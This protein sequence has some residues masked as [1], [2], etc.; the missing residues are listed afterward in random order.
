M[1]ITQFWQQRIM[2]T[3]CVHQGEEKT[4]QATPRRKERAYKEGQ[5]AVSHELSRALVSALLLFVWMYYL[6]TLDIKLCMTDPTTFFR[7]LIVFGVV[8]LLIN[9]CVTGIQTKFHH[10]PL[11][12]NFNLIKPPFS[13]FSQAIN[14]AFLSIAKIACIGLLFY[15]LV[16]HRTTTIVKYAQL[17]TISLYHVVN[18]IMSPFLYALVLCHFALGIA[19]YIWKYM[20][21]K[22]QLRMSKYEVKREMIEQEG[23]PAIKFKR[24]Q[25]HEKLAHNMSL[26]DATIVITNPTH[27]AVALYWDGTDNP[28]ALIA[29]TDHDIK[30]FASQASCAPCV[31]VPAVSRG[32]YRELEPGDYVSEKYYD[33]LAEVMTQNL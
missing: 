27:L 30:G 31:R 3:F 32:L 6:P 20:Q 1:P 18:Y 11:K 7:P 5:I 28:P 24:K 8:V 21:N 14:S 2:L 19:D 9:G 23:N 26:S 22:Q 16:L 10:K 15:Y 12:L 17:D 25:F 4:E 29:K 33:D 13:N